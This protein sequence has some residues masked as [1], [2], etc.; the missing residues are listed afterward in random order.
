MELGKELLKSIQIII[1]RKLSTYN[2][3]RTYQSIIKKITPKGYVVLD[4]N[5]SERTVPC[6]I[7]NLNLRVMQRIWLKEPCGRLADLH[8]CGIVGK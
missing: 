8:I 1:D 2:C 5:G 7:P 4:S 3:D 6:C